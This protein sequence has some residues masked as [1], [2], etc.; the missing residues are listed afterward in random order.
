MRARWCSTDEAAA[1]LAAAVEAL[2][3]ATA[4]LSSEAANGRPIG[5]RAMALAQS[6][7]RLSNLSIEAAS[8]LQSADAQVLTS[9]LQSIV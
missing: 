6:L 1:S 7:T 2:R 3:Q 5:D 9:P 4:G 8:H